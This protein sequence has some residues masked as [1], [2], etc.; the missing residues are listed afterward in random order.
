MTTPPAALHLALVD[1]QDRVRIELTGDLDY[2]N[3]NLLL[4]EVGMVLTNR[5]RLKELHLHCASLGAIDSM[6]LSA[7]LTIRRRTDAAA[8]HL[9]LTER[10]AQLNRILDIT[11]TLDF[12][13]APPPTGAA[14]TQHTARPAP[15][16]RDMRAARPT[17][18]DGTH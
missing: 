1:G 6:G 9:H 7:L 2:D 14:D 3:A 17:G 10:T 4:E 13:T 16:G 15:A 5:P 12:F 11:G 18:P 8:V